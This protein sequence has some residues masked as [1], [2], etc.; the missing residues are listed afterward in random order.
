MKLWY[1]RDNHTFR[2]LSANVEEAVAVIRSEF[3]AGFNQGSFTTRAYPN[4]YIA[5]HGDLPEFEK[6]VRDWYATNIPNK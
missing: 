4:G 5:A 2:E 3:E 1:M 6:E